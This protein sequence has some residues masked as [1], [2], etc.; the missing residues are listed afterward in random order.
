MFLSKMHQEIQKCGDQKKVCVGIAY[1]GFVFLSLLIQS[2]DEKLHSSH[3]YRALQKVT[4]YF[5][6]N[7]PNVGKNLIWN[8]RNVR[9]PLQK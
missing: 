2:V 5:L 8:C 3:I 7:I 6:S 9:N 4:S 1:E